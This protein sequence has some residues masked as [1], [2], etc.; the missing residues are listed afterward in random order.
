MKWLLIGIVFCIATIVPYA[1]CA[2]ESAAAEETEI[3]N[4]T[5][6]EPTKLS[7]LVYQNTASLMVSR[8]GVVAVFYPKPGRGRNFTGSRLIAGRRGARK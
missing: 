8:T 2:A 4:I 5:V 1:S 6:G 7:D 3:L